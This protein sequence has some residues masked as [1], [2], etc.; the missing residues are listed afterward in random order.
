MNDREEELL[1]YVA[2][3]T[4]PLTAWAALP[5]DENEPPSEQHKGGLGCA[6]ALIVAA[7]ILLWLAF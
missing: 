6:V 4:D 2:A 3:G 1:T 7:L 5:D